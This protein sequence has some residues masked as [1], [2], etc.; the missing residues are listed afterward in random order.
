M[1]GGIANIF[2]SALIVCAWGFFLLSGVAD[3]EGGTKALW[4][5]FGIANEL[6]L[7][8][9]NLQQTGSFKARGAYNAIAGLSAEERARGVITYSSGNH[10]QA[11][12]FAERLVGQAFG[13]GEMAAISVSLLSSRRLAF[14]RKS[15]LICSVLVARA[16][17]RT[18]A[19]FEL[20]PSAMLPADLA[21][22]YGV[23]P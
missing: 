7:K 14:T 13:F 1:C 5:I 10:G 3:P 15:H 2:A 16:L 11:V 22:H 19:V 9:E 8:A 20:D 18:D 23:K 17:E 4:P 12:A 6:W 21:K